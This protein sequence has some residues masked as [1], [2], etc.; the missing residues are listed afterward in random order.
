MDDPT[1][2]EA[3]AFL[4]ALDERDFV[5]VGAM[6]GLRARPATS[7]DTTLVEKYLEN[8]FDFGSEP[9]N[10]LIATLSDVLP[11]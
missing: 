2:S 9:P 1:P 7:A 11:Q 5:R 8:E 10:P 3:D 4:L 6:L